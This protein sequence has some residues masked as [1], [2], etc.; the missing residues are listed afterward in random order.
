MLLRNGGLRV[1]ALDSILCGFMLLDLWLGRSRCS[2]QQRSWGGGSSIH[3][4]GS[5]L[6]PIPSARILI[7]CLRG[8]LGGLGSGSAG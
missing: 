4:C 3:L 7:R 6:H 8:S 2:G 1:G 5:M